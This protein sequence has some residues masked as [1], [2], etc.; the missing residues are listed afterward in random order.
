[1]LRAK[2]LSNHETVVIEDGIT[3]LFDIGG[4]CYKEDA[5]DLNKYMTGAVEF[6]YISVLSSGS[7]AEI[8]LFSEGQAIRKF[9]TDDLLKCVMSIQM[10]GNFVKMLR[11]DGVSNNI[12]F[13]Q[14]IFLYN[15]GTD[16]LGKLVNLQVQVKEI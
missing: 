2:F 15:K 9:I 7:R 3:Y 14:L 1:M 5:G 6:D 16:L 4:K 11:R 12:R 8:A 13:N 10:A